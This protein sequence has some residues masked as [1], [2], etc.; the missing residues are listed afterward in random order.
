M[1]LPRHELEREILSLKDRLAVAV[2]AA[3]AA[4]SLLTGW[5]SENVK[6]GTDY[7]RLFVFIKAVANESAMAPPLLTRLGWREG[8][9]EALTLCQEVAALEHGLD[10]TEWQAACRSVIERIERKLGPAGDMSA[11]QDPAPIS[12]SDAP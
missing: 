9:R 7:Q 6:K 3:R 10:P 12:G 1:I 5:V 8:M 11:T 4:R 2:E